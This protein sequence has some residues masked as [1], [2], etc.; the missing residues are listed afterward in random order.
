MKGMLFAFLAFFFPWIVF[1][2]EEKLGLAFLAM[3]FQVTIIGWIPMTMLAYKH[4]ENLSY[5]KKK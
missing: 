3:A 2:L 1:L 5:F 4:R